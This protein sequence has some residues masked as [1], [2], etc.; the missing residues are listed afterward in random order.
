V[1]ASAARGTLTFETVSSPESFATLASEWD[2]LVRA[3][4]RPSPG[5][6]HGW[7]QA[8][9]DTYGKEAELSIQ[10]ARRD[11]ELIGALPLCVQRR[12]GLR[13]LTFVGGDQSPLS[14]LMLAEGESRDVATKLLERAEAAPH[15]FADLSGLPGEGQLTSELG[16]KAHLIERSEAP[17]LDLADGWEAVYQRKTSSKS[18]SLHRRRRRQLAELGHLEV[19][20][21][22]T[23]DELEPALEDAFRLHDLRWAGR[24]DGSRFATPDGQRFHRTAIRALAEADAARI[25]LLRLDG[26]AI[27][28]HY[29]FRLERR[30][31]VN[32]IAF[33]PALGRHSPGLVNTL[34]ALEAGAAEGAT[35]VEFLGGAERYKVDL[36]D[37]LEPLYEAIGLP[38]SLRGRA[39]VTVRTRA[40]LLR[41]S[42]KRS[43]ALRKFYFDGLAPTRKLLARITS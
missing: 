17:V 15:D 29:Y 25:V 38:G 10:I 40:I 14:D 9:L 28:F 41:K 19:V 30:M 43:Q 5:L 26:R 8:W 7:L 35:R 31:Y 27:A 32:R 4:P 39:A 3:M 6:L 36:A 33:D 16:G 18:K 20:V 2:G 37:R 12:S 13:V 11:G 24:P 1:V 42:L 21:A 22:R 23:I 34:D